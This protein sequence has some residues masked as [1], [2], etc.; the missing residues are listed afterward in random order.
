LI[1]YADHCIQEG[2]VLGL[3]GQKKNNQTRKKLRNRPSA[4]IARGLGALSD[5]ERFEFGLVLVN[6][7]Y[8]E[9]GKIYRAKKPR[10]G[11]LANTL[12]L[13]RNGASPLANVFGVGSSNG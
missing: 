8:T 9:D 13:F 5:T 7:F 2:Q 12:N 10:Q 3:K 4:Q 11:V 6:I 1:I